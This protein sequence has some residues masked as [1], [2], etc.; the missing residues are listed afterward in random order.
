MFFQAISRTGAVIDE[1]ILTT[2]ETGTADATRPP[3]LPLLRSP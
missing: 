1:G 2:R 3:V